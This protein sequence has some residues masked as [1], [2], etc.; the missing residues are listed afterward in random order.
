MKRIAIHYIRDKSKSIRF[1]RPSWYDN[2]T[3]FK[4]IKEWTDDEIAIE[5][6][7]IR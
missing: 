6:A 7:I 3:L 5:H 2:N 4:P 1:A